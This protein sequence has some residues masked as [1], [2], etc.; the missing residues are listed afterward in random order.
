MASLSTIG[1]S[2]LSL[3][4][5]LPATSSRATSRRLL[6]RPG[7]ERRRASKVSSALIR[8]PI[9]PAAPN[10]FPAEVFFECRT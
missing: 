8:F 4:P 2:R 1:A 6:L 7:E 3:T 9:L 10:R 5:W